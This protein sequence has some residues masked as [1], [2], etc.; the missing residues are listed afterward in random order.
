MQLCEG[1]W[2]LCG[3]EGGLGTVSAG[4]Q[5]LHRKWARARPP[6]QGHERE[7]SPAVPLS[8]GVAVHGGERAAAALGLPAAPA[9][10]HEYSSLDVTLELVRALLTA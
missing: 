4:T 6:S 1:G 5:C 2:R 8:A 9:A 10:R 7:R 3:P